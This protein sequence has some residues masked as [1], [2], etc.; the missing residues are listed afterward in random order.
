MKG[1]LKTVL[2]S[3]AVA[4]VIA[5]ATAAMDASGQGLEKATFAGGC[6]W[7]MEPPFDKLEG[8]Q[9]VVS[10][11]TGGDKKNPTYEEVSSGSTGHAESVEITYDPTVISYSRLLDV[12][13]H[14]IDPTVKDRQFCDVGAQYRTAIFYHSAEQKRLAEAS[15]KALEQSKRFPGP[16]YTEITA[17]ATFYPA[18]EYHQKYYQKNPVRYKL[19]RFNC[20]RDQRL[21]ELWG[22]P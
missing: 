7:C 15:K 19:Y 3:I 22:Q 14:N 4:L 20:G 21:R 2:L 9:S 8:V 5:A 6:F 11:Y 16:I 1:T 12:F 17:A 13:W 18:E 10:G